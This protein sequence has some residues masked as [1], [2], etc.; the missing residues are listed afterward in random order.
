MAELYGGPDTLCLWLTGAESPGATQTRHALS[1]GAYASNTRGDGL[2]HRFIDPVRGLRVVFA[3]GANGAGDGVLT[4][5]SDGTVTWRAPGEST[6]GSA[7]SIAA[8]ESKVVLGD[9]DSK[10]VVVYRYAGVTPAGSGTVMLSATEN[11]AWVGNDVSSAQQA[12]GVT[13]YRSL[14]LWN[15]GL[16]TAT[17][18]K[19][20]Q[21][22]DNPVGL[23]WG[24]DDTRD[25][26]MPYQDISV[27]GETHAPVVESWNSGTTDATGLQIASLAPNDDRGIHFRRVIAAD[28]TATPET[29]YKIYVSFVFGGVTYTRTGIATFRIADTD[30]QT[31]LV[32]K[33]FDTDVDFDT[34]Y[35][36]FTS[37]PYS[38]AGLPDGLHK[39][40]IRERN[41]YGLISQDTTE[42]SVRVDSGAETE[43]PP[44]SPIDVSAVPAADGK[45]L[46][47]AAY[48]FEDDTAAQRAD[49]WAVWA[50]AGSALDPDTD[51]ATYTEAMT[52]GYNVSTLSTELG[53]FTD[54]ATVYVSVRARRTGPPVSDSENTGSVTAV[55]DATAPDDI[56]HLSCQYGI[57]TDA[58]ADAV[59]VWSSGTDASIERIPATNIW[60]FK[61]G[62]VVVAAVN[63]FGQFH[64]ETMNELPFA[65]DEAMTEL[66][67]YHAGEIWI[68]A[69][70]PIYRV[71]TIDSTGEVRASEFE[72]R[73]DYP[74]AL[75]GISDYLEYASEFE[76]RYDYPVALS[77]ISDYLE[78]NAAETATI[79]SSDLLKVVLSLNETTI[80]G[81]KNATLKAKGFNEYNL[82]D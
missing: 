55:A 56:D 73:Y 28:T 68:G 27:F 54:G 59:T 12:A 15:R 18:I 49:T 72:E 82:V 74:V 19:I 48:L 38:E 52:T 21:D 36:T 9:T 70:G 22:E 5:K 80:G 81:F 77:G 39:Y 16:A 34:I 37:F 46:V 66:I 51:A 65:T 58:L 61:I 23:S 11:A 29:E 14:G 78:Y 45:I 10:Y 35:D 64:C 24:I 53:P 30:L 76:E 31:Y 6:A 13:T 1:L 60:R 26:S 33:G 41:E 32:Y 2:A 57:A 44:T 17:S 42:I 63:T 71:V 67:E 69:G 3:A 47:T 79:F 43:D 75:S 50:Q 8:G 7:V 4:A 20:W 25:G 62:G 40:V